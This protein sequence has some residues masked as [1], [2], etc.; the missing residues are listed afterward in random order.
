MAQRLRPW[1][2]PALLWMSASCSYCPLDCVPQL[3]NLCCC[4]TVP[5]IF[6][7]AHTG[8]DGVLEGYAL[9]Y[10]AQDM[11]PCRFHEVHG[12]LFDGF[13]WWASIQDGPAFALV[14][15]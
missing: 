6:S 1:P 2:V 13:T 3:D 9:T 7:D 5:V 12:L 10:P 8:A 11:N 15:V 4:L 14:V